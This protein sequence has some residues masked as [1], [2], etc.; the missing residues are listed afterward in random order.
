MADDI[1]LSNRLRDRVAAVLEQMETMPASSPQEVVQLTRSL[2]AISTTL[3]LSSDTLRQ[4]LGVNQRQLH[5]SNTQD[6][7]ELP[8]V[9]LTEEEVEEIRNHAETLST[10]ISDGLGGTLGEENEIVTEGFTEA[11]KETEVA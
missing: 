5:Q 7:P 11:H 1:A 4:T 2:A 9:N 8:I 10:G 3:K 6:L